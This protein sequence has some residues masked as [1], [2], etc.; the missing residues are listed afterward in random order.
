MMNKEK[1]KPD[2]IIIGSMKCGTTT[3]YSDLSQIQSLYM[4]SE[5]EPAI[6]TK[7]S[8]QDKIKSEYSRHFKGAADNQLCGEA[9]TDYTKL[10]IFEGVVDKAYQLCGNNLK[11]IMIM[12]DP[13]ERIYSHLKHDIAGGL[14]SA[15][16]IDRVVLENAEY[17]AISDYAKQLLPWISRFGIENLLCVSFS[18]LKKNRIEVINDVAK[19]LGV[20]IDRSIDIEAVQ[21]K[22]TELR[23]TGRLASLVVNSLVYRQYIRPFISDSVR[24]RLRKMVLRKVAIPDI[25]LSNH[26]EDVLRQKLSNVEPDV[27]SLIGKRIKINEFKKN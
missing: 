1:N 26:T 24:V 22:G 23:R 5:K 7:F 21:N 14:I 8:D 19:F 27:E 4:P 15:D 16:E 12:R 11:L 20:K 9:S 13:I 3:L 2:F 25:K 18:D 17:L 10:P 6:L